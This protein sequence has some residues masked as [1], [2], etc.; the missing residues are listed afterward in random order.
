MY[1]AYV[2]EGYV[3]SIQDINEEARASVR[4]SVR[5]TE[6]FEMRAGLLQGS[7]LSPFLLDIIMD[8]LRKGVRK[9]T[10]WDIMYAGNI[11]LGQENKEEL[12]V[13]VERWR[14][15]IEERGLKVSKERWNIF[16]LE[17]PS[18][19]RFTYRGRW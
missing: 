2:S 17:E 8:M 5:L 19:K 15:V 7:A 11:V 18:R 14:K 13:S 9:D 6:D 10:P 12:E 3:E 1:H 16:Q 4:N